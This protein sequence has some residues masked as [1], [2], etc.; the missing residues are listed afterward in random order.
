MQQAETG[1]RRPPCPD[2]CWGKYFPPC[3]CSF[4]VQPNTGAIVD[5]CNIPA[6]LHDKYRLARFRVTKARAGTRPLLDAARAFLNGTALPWLT[7]SGPVGNGKS[8]I[9]MAIVLESVYAGISAR[10]YELDRLLD[11]LWILV[12]ANDGGMGYRDLLD[13]LATV[14]VLAIDDIKGDLFNTQWRTSQFEKIVQSRYTQERRTVWTTNLLP[15]EELSK[16][17]TRAADR[18]SDK[19]IARLVVTADPSYRQ[20]SH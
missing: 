20:E 2:T 1:V 6:D 12:R 3:T 7:I 15:R 13:D 16:I 18:L 19:G 14:D 8:H 11:D 4:A 9:A 10:Y 5:A 17:T